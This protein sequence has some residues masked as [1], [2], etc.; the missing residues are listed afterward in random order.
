MCYSGAPIVLAYRSQNEENFLDTLVQVFQYFEAIP[1]RVIFDNGKI[2]AKDGLGAHARKQIGYAVLTAHYSFKAV[3]CN[4]VSGNEKGL[5][6]ELVGY[7]RRNVCAP[8][9]NAEHIEEL[10]R[11]LQE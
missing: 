3:F 6:D 7:I 5:V 2:A 8:V 1:K 10:N 11:M 9:P 4:P